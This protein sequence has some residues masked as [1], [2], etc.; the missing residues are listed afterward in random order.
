VTRG[1]CVAHLTSARFRA[2]IS[3]AS[4]S[5]L[6]LASAARA[7]SAA[8]ISR[9]FARLQR[10]IRAENLH[11]RLRRDAAMHDQSRTARSASEDC[12]PY[13]VLGRD[14]TVGHYPTTAPPTIRV[15]RRGRRVSLV[16]RAA[17]P[18]R[19][20]GAEGAP[21]TVYTPL[22]SVHVIQS[23]PPSYSVHAPIQYTRNTVYTP[24]VQCTRPCTVYT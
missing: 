9:R 7:S 3:A 19:G 6:A 10:F 17:D 1:T 14:E 4:V 20:G 16:P 2:A 5:I 21:R 23:T 22:Y 18:S 13:R 24:F 15:W 11:N 8:W 12:V